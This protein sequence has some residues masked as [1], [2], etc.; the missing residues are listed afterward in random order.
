MFLFA[1]TQSHRIRIW[2]PCP[3]ADPVPLSA[4]GGIGVSLQHARPATITA[5]GDLTAVISDKRSDIGPGR[6]D[7]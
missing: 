3:A 7:R 1:V 5:I 6:R 4:Y 2:T